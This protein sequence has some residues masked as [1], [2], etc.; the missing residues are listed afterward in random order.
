M[1]AVLNPFMDRLA[2]YPMQRL[3]ILISNVA[4]PADL[5]PIKLSIGEPKHALPD[6]ITKAL[7]DS[8]A[9]VNAYPSIWAQNELREA[10]AEWVARRFSPAILDP[11]KEILPVN[12]AREGLFSF[13]RTV[14][15]TTRIGSKVICP[16]PGYAVYEGVTLLSGLQPYYLA[17]DTSDCSGKIYESVSEEVWRET[18]V[19]FV[20]SPDNPKGCTLSQEG[21]ERLFALSDKY[22]FYLV[23][24][25]CYSEIFV[26]ENNPPVGALQAASRAGRDYKRLAAFFSL[27]KRSN[28]PG[29]RSGFIAGDAEVLAKVCQYRSYNGGGMSPAVQSASIAAWKDE[30]HV[31]A[32]R[33][34]YKAKYDEVIP[35]LQ[36]VLDVRRPAAGFFLW[37]DIRRTGLSDEEFTRQ[38]YA[39][40]NV[41]VL[42]GTYLTHEVDGHDPGEGHVRIA[43]VAGVEE[44]LEG[45]RRINA[46][47]DSLANQ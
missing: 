47:C 19:V 12:G 44:C 11:R 6:V 43:L 9:S 27:S 25:E 16:N 36:R 29:L 23:S 10:I 3:E 46:F 1:S 40:Q 17:T 13:V 38:L 2:P 26:D 33:A 42:P 32:N 8:A 24:D 21:W 14:V 39:Q 4:P 22:G 15:D 31:V 30:T 20:C 37:A 34:L 5:P 45:A 18:Q 7:S 35:L 28:A 41:L